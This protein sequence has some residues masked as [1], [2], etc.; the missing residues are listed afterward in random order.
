MKENKTTS[1][2]DGLAL[3]N[4]IV[5]VTFLAAGGIMSLVIPKERI[6]ESEKREL[7]PMPGFNQDN[8]FAGS[9]TDSLDL[10]Y[11]DNF[12]FRDGFVEISGIVKESFGYRANDVK[13]YTTD[14]EPVTEEPELDTVAIAKIDTVAEVKKLDSAGNTKDFGHYILIHGGMAFQIFGGSETRATN[15][16][17]MVNAYRDALGDS[18]NVYCMIVPSSISFYLP[19]DVRANRGKERP[20]IQISY[21]HLDSGVIA[22][23]SYSEIEKHTDEYIYFNT[24][25]HWTAR[26][27]YYAYRAF[28]QRA[29]LVPAELSSLQRKVRKGYLGSLYDITKD[30]SLKENRDSVETFNI[31]AV[32]ETF[33]YT[34]GDLKNPVKAKLISGS[35]NYATFLGGD[36]PM[37]R[38]KTEN[39]NGRRALVI[40]D[41]FGNAVC[42][43][44]AMNFE[45]VIVVDYRYFERNLLTFIRKNGVTDFIFLHNTFVTNTDFVV[46]KERYLMRARDIIEPRVNPD[47]V[48]TPVPEKKVEKP[49]SIK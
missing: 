43:F 47:T 9:Y 11:S 37:V 45:E 42:P 4:I 25:H 24:D 6:S 38:I 30:V 41:S 34:S 1:R 23:D 8:L 32:T 7:T 27:A 18:I 12:P 14:A 35:V 5:F 15:F 10:Y 49:D 21:D 2:K 17:S 20:N 33:R 39:L 26:G 40:K 46:K 28:C 48:K 44:L 3:A 16:A 36:F 19:P 13:I 22:V 29:G 31:P